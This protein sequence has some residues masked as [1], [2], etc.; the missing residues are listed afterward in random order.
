MQ[1]LKQIICDRRLP[2]GERLNAGDEYIK[3]GANGEIKM[4]Y[5][6]VQEANK[7]K[8]LKERERFEQEEMEKRREG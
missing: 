4:I 7:K 5:E 3:R 8:L 2:D 6:S 1:Q